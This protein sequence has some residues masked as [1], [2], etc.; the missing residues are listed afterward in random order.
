MDHEKSE[1][2][3]E[4][5]NQN[6]T[7]TPK[8]LTPWQQEHQRYLA[9]KKKREAELAAE[10][11]V[12]TEVEGTSED[13]ET[14]GTDEKTE[15]SFKVVESTEGTFLVMDETTEDSQA[16]KDKT[17]KESQ[18]KKKQRREKEDVK[19]KTVK[20]LP[21]SKSFADK[22]PKLK[23]TR[24]KRLQKRLVVIVG[25]FSLAAIGMI[26]YVSPLS[27]LNK[28]QVVGNTNVSDESIIASTQLTSDERIWSALFNQSTVG[29]VEKAN[30]RIKSA[31]V[32]LAQLNN[33][34][35]TIEEYKEVAYVNEKDT[36][37]P[38]L[39]NG[40]IL[41]ETSEV[42]EVDHPVLSGFTEG[43]GLDEVLT[44][45]NE[46]DQPIR[47][48]IKEIKSTPVKRNKYLI[49]FKMNDGNEIIASSKDY[50]T[51]IN[52]YPKVVAEMKDK[53]VVDMEAGIFASTYDA[54]KKE[55][56]EASKKEKEEASQKNV[57]GQ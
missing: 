50:Y 21:K 24:K 15:K 4:T 20:D 28:V 18:R 42:I 11:K 26:Y 34:K 36:L 52:Y 17:T 25:V 16:T 51:K 48:N 6:E 49:T 10:I 13:S 1:L 27:Y 22:L 9:E 56:E 40:K 35:V 55:K 29:K 23:K 14:D 2:E 37:H 38:V 45:F 53:G 3:Q 12:E 8:V 19:F 41:N 43:E 47:E 31:K 57:D 33:L 44:H 5:E 39:E 32:S 7:P 30:P 54:I 46:I